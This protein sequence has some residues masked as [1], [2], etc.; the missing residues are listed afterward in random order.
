MG[1]GMFSGS[2]DDGV[3]RDDVYTEPL[4]KP[5]KFTD[6][7]KHIKPLVDY[8]RGFI[9]VEGETSGRLDIRVMEYR[10]SNGSVFLCAYWKEEKTLFIKHQTVE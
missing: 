9:T 8:E 10:E 6:E 4:Y 5:F 1:L 2:K 3:F 7:V